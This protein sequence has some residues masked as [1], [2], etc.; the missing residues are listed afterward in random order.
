MDLTAAQR[1]AW[2]KAERTSLSDG[3]YNWIGNQLEQL[4]A[5]RMLRDVLAKNTATLGAH[6][7]APL[8]L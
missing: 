6:A 2:L 4:R 1:K 8:S 3:L 5:G 7:P